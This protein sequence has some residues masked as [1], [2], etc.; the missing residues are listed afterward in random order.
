MSKLLK[1][2]KGF[3]L[4]EVVIVLAIAA[5]IILVVL[6]AVSSANK[7]NR[8]TAR[9]SEAGRVVSLVEQYASNNNGLYPATAALFKTQMGVYDP[10]LATKYTDAASGSAL[11]GTTCPA[12]VKSNTYALVYTAASNARSY[13]LS[14]CLENVAGPTTVQH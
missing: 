14:E 7:S 13:T 6:Q 1:K 2:E 11:D 12:S 3:T 10:G 5:L 8:D 4:I 9:K